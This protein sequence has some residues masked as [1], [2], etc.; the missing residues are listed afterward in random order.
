MNK[1]IVLLPMLA[2]TLLAAVACNLPMPTPTPEAEVCP[3]EELAAPSLNTPADAATLTDT[4]PTLTWTYPD[5]CHPEGYR[6]DL[7]TTADFS[8]TSLSGGTGNPSTSWSPGSDLTPGV[9]YYW[10]VAPIN[11]TTLGPF[12]TSR[13]FW[14]GPTCPTEELVAP[15]LNSPADGST[16]TGDNPPLFE[17]TNPLACDP[18]G[19]RIDVSVT[20][21]FSDTSL[22][23]GTGNPSTSWFSH[24]LAD[25]TT[26]YWQVAPINGTTL[27]PFSS[28]W[29]FQTDFAGTCAGGGAAGAATT[30]EPTAE[31][32]SEPTAEPTEDTGSGAAPA[33]GVADFG[34][35]GPY[36]PADGA[37]TPDLNPTLR[38]V[39]GTDSPCTPP[40]YQIQLSTNSTF[41]VT[42]LIGQA[43]HSGNPA[44]SPGTLAAGTTYYWRVAVIVSPG[45]LASWSSTFSFTTPAGPTA[46]PAASCEFTAPFLKSPANGAVVPDDWPS[47][48]WQYSGDCKPPGYRID[49]ATDPSFADTSLAGG[50]GNPSTSWAAG[51]P[52]EVCTTYYWMVRAVSTEGHLG[53]SSATWSFFITDG[54]CQP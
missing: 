12:S 31:V 20:S 10:R 45:V 34:P 16:V 25:C 17:W 21:D 41:A 28:A 2:V 33:C 47:L 26:Y 40:Q 30:E 38:W 27:G 37:T 44:W 7:S 53:P 22:S 19:Y 54:K 35:P 8:D 39:Y 49:L 43:P 51:H 32:T 36:D 29:S 50:T 15:T 11:G 14:I 1:R 46:V 13:R 24:E 48:R 4:L 3:T 9:V 42:P 6:I 23:G 52:L 18:E 5:P